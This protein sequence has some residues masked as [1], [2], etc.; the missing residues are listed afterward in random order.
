MP[1]FWYDHSFQSWFRIF[2]ICFVPPGWIPCRKTLLVLNQGGHGRLLGVAVLCFNGN[3]W[4]KDLP[5]PLCWAWAT[6]G[7]AVWLEKL[8]VT[9]ACGQRSLFGSIVRTPAKTNWPGRAP[10][11]Q[12]SQKSIIHV[13]CTCEE[14]QPA[15]SFL[16]CCDW[17]ELIWQI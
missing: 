12:M 10:K 4:S 5:S 11:Q 8:T 13:L 7:M 14:L 1:V 9:T 15:Y 3:F 17:E 16:S 2:L 6:A